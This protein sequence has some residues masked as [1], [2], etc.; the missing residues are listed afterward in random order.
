MT[1]PIKKS[2]RLYKSSFIEIGIWKLVIEIRICTND[3][4][5]SSSHNRQTLL[6][7]LTARIVLD[8]AQSRK[9]RRQLSVTTFLGSPEVSGL[10]QAKQ[11]SIHQR[12]HLSDLARGDGFFDLCFANTLHGADQPSD[13]FAALLHGA[14]R[15]FEDSMRVKG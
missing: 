9:G 4:T 6:F 7:T 13:E 10:L 14:D 8:K 3:T 2:L 1:T 15:I 12:H 5:G 11:F